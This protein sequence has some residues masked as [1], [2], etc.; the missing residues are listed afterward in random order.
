MKLH[1]ATNEGTIIESIE[2]DGMNLS[3]PL[4]LV[5]IVGQIR[6]AVERH[7]KT[8]RMVAGRAIIASAKPINREPDVESI[9]AYRARMD[10]IRGKLKAAGLTA[11]EVVELIAE[12]DEGQRCPTHPLDDGPCEP[13]KGE[14]ERCVYGEHDIPNRVSGDG[15][16]GGSLQ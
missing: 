12:P 4:A 2:L 7:Q 6:E 14:P 10:E 11:D 9:D 8:E 3:K 16:V 1:V 5:D 15:P 13:L